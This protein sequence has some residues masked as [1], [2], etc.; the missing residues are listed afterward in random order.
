M[1]ARSKY[2]QA[3]RA[4]RAPTTEPQPVEVVHENAADEIPTPSGWE[5][6]PELTDEE[7]E[8]LTAP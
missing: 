7:L 6:A 2:E 8:A 4:R 3:F 5:P 1:R